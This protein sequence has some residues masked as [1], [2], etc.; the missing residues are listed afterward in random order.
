MSANDIYRMPDGFDPDTNHY[1]GLPVPN[2]IMCLNQTCPDSKRCRR[3]KDSGAVPKAHYQTYNVFNHNNKK[4]CAA[5]YPKP[6]EHIKD[7]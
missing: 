4:A 7:A 1:K 6:H 5:Y 3:H 2:I